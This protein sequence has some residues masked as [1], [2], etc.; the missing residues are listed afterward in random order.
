ML[1]SGSPTRAAAGRAR[2]RQ[3]T[4]AAPPGVNATALQCHANRHATSSA[5]IGANRPGETAAAPDWVGKHEYFDLSRDRRHTYLPRAELRGDDVV[6]LERLLALEVHAQQVGGRALDL[7]L[8]L[9]EVLVDLVRE[10]AA[11]DEHVVVGAG[12]VLDRLEERSRVLDDE[13]AQPVP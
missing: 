5:T 3:R 11:E 10:D 9:A 12:V 8:H 4:P 6:G 1:Q 7:R 2:S 13:L